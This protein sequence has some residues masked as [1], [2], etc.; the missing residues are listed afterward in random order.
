[1]SGA[2][3]YAKN[4]KKAVRDCEWYCAFTS[5]RITT[6]KGDLIPTS[7]TCR[8]YPNVHPVSPWPPSSGGGGYY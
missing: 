1:M 3:R 8:G 4:A 5:A 2:W 7:C 6:R